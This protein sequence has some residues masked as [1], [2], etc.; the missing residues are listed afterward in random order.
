MVQTRMDISGSAPST[1]SMRFDGLN[2]EVFNRANTPNCR[3]PPWSICTSTGR[4]RLWV[5]TLQGLVVREEE[6][7]GAG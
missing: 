4:D 3:L 6:T 2:F 1:D 7:S 5:S